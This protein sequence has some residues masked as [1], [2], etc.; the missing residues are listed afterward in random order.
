M[1]SLSSKNKGVKYLLCVIDVFSNY[2]WV[3]PLRDKKSKTVLNGYI[4][5]LNKSNCK[6]DKLSF[7]QERE[8]YNSPI[9]EWLVDNDVLICS[10]LNEGK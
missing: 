5:I 2:A 4:E 1:G 6:P 3:I 10:T 7:Y 8:F 9:Q